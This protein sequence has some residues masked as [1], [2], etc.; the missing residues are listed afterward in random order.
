MCDRSPVGEV[1]VVPYLPPRDPAVELEVLHGEPARRAAPLGDAPVNRHLGRARREAPEGRTRNGAVV[2][3]LPVHLRVELRAVGQ[4]CRRSTSRAATASSRPTWGC[5]RSDP[6]TLEYE[7]LL[8]RTLTAR[9]RPRSTCRAA[10]TMCWSIRTCRCSRRC[11]SCAACG[12]ISADK[13]LSEIWHFRLKGAPEAI[14][15][16]KPVV[17]QPRQ[18]AGD[19][20]QRRRP[21]E[22]EQ[23]PVGA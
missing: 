15:R 18:L 7:A 9:K 10:S 5:A 13:T 3:P 20:D 1:E 8:V 22:L 2:L 19:D 14:Y 11:S 4:P 17:L 12:P 23:G 16:Q 21:G 6:D